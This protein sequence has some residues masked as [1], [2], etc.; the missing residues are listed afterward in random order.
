MSVA[1]AIEPAER[2]RRPRR[3]GRTLEHDRAPGGERGCELRERELDRVVV[4]RDRGRRRRP[5]PSRSSGGAGRRRCRARRGLRRTRSPRADRRT[6]RTTSIGAFELR[7][8][9]ARD[10]RADLVHEDLAQRLDVVEQRLVELAQAPHAATRGRVDHVGRVERAPGRGDRS[11]G[12]GDARVG[13][14]AEHLLGRRRRSSRRSRRPSAAHQ[15]AVDE[16]PVLV[17]DR[18]RVSSRLCSIAVRDRWFRL[19][20]DD[21]GNRERLSRQAD[22]SFSAAAHDADRAPHARSPTSAAELRT[23]WLDAHH[24]ELAPPYAPPGTLDEHIAQMQRVKS[25]LFDA[26]WMRYGWPERVGGL[27]RLTDAAHR[28]RRGARRPRPRRSRALLADRGA[29]ADADRLRAAR[30]SRPRSFPACSRAPRCGARA[31]RSRAPAATC[32]VAELPR[33]LP[34]ATPTTASTWVINGQKVWTSLAQYS[35]RCVLLTRTGRAGVA[36]PRHHRVLRRHGHARAS[37]SRR[38]R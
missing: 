19:G 14:D 2:E 32:R 17:P 34:T 3:V 27:G 16:Q 24:D 20:R 33:R 13:R 6:S 9:R 38:S 4:R 21:Y 1:S 8:A 7:T 37:P 36:P 18:H 25:I 30:R 22:A 28:A 5:L 29:R 11:F 31:S 10:R 35:D 12:V 26:G 23:P 15:L